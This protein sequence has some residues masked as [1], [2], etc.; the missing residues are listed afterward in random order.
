MKYHYLQ[1]G[2]ALLMLCGSDL[3]EKRIKKSLHF[4]SVDQMLK[5]VDFKRILPS[6]R[7]VNDIQ[8]IYSS[9]PGYKEKVRKF[10]L[11]AFEI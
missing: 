8:E 10:G 11:M 9:F 6:G 7:S 1:P 2:D 4:A 5:Q 3:V